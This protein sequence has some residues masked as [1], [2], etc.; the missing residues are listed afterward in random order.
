MTAVHVRVRVAGEQYALP[1]DG[2]LEVAELGDVTPVPGAPSSVLGV[3]NLRGQL[4]PVVDL[5]T[6]FGL[7]GDTPRERIVIAEA[8]DRRAG[9]AVES[10]LA[11]E[12]VSQPTEAAASAYLRGAVLA[13]GELVGI[14]DL[15]A[16]LDSVARERSPQ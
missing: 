6:L 9:L 3:R 14:V 15:G 12:P 16:A 1:V 10:I 5:A 11:V 4:I 8:G 2:V 13:D 7:D